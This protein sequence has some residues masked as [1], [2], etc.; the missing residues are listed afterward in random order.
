MRRRR[1]VANMNKLKHS[2]LGST[3]L[4]GGVQT[5]AP[6]SNREKEAWFSAPVGEGVHLPPGLGLGVGW[7]LRGMRGASDIQNSNRESLR[8][9]TLVTQRKHGS[10][11]SIVSAI[12]KQSPQP[13]EILT[14][15]T[16][17]R[18]KEAL[19]QVWPGLSIVS[20]IAEK[21]IQPSKIMTNPPFS[22]RRIVISRSARRRANVRNT[23]SLPSFLLRLKTTP[24]VCFVEFARSFNRT[25][26]RLER[27][28]KRMKNERRRK[29]QEPRA[30]MR[31]LPRQRRTARHT[32]SLMTICARPKSGLEVT[33]CPARHKARALRSDGAAALE[34]QKTFARL[35]HPTSAADFFHSRPQAC[36]GFACE[37]C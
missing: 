14:G 5:P 4:R 35:R 13:G 7:D 2:G 37:S 32:V 15:P 16:S 18:E 24:I 17:N 27:L 9:E 36:T 33:T 19:F 23:K 25:M 10:G 1:Q 22:S 29:N 21:L 3:P 20:A 31:R 12:A 6:I 11:L 34:S 26:F 28:A 8:L 30:Q